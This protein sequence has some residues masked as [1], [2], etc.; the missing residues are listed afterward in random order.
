MKTPIYLM[1]S[2]LVAAA[3][4]ADGAGIRDRGVNARQR[5]QRGRLAEGVRS[6]ELTKSEAKGLEKEERNIRVEERQFK[7][8]GKLTL[9][10]NGFA[11]LVMAHDDRG[12]ATDVALFDVDGKP[13]LHV[14]TNQ[15]CAACHGTITWTAA[16]FSHV[17]ISAMCQS[18]HNGITATGKQVQHVRTTLDC[19]SCHNTLNWTVVSAPA[20]VPARPRPL[21]PSPRGAPSGPSK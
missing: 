15:D 1:L 10:K 18:C 21:I 19:G 2:A 12:N 17:G 4:C 3:V 14:Q 16:R 7:S 6:G 20:N 8:D 9:Q 11:T 5:N 13:T